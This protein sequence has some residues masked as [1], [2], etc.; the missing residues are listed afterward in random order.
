MDRLGWIDR[1]I[2]IAAVGFSFFAG[3]GGTPLF[4]K[5]EGAFCEA[6]REMVAGGDYV[7]PYLNG[8]PRYDKPILIYWLQAVGV[9]LFGLNEFAVRFPSAVAAAAWA[10]I[11]YRF[12][13]R[14]LDVEKAFLATF[15]L[16]TAVQVTIIA[17][18]AIADAVLNFFIALS[19]FSFYRYY[20]SGKKDPY[21]IGVTAMALGMLTKGPVAILIPLATTF[22]FCWL[23]K[24][25]KRWSKAVAN[26]WG[27]LLFLLIAGPWYLIAIWDQGRPILHAWI[28]KQTIQRLHRPLEGHGGRFYYY[29]PIVLGG[30]MPYTA[31]LFKAM[32]RVRSDFKAPLTR[33]LLIWFVFVFVFF[34]FSGTKLPHYVIY[35]Y[36]GLFIVFAMHLDRVRRDFLLMLPALVLLVLLLLPAY[37]IPWIAPRVKDE[38]ARAVIRECAGEFGWR[39]QIPIFAGLAVTLGLALIPGI[40]R[41]TRVVALGFLVA[42]LV[43]L[44]LMTLAGRITQAPVK[45]AA[46]IARQHDYD[47]RLWKF[48]MPSFI[49]YRE[50]LLPKGLPLEGDIVL[51]KINLLERLA[52][53]EIL[54][55]KN[56]VV[57]ARILHVKSYETPGKAN[58][59]LDDF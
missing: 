51:T 29:V 10:W 43:N 44:H 34:S 47:A 7:M 45:E 13:R 30:V 9:W 19:M 46:R 42:G 50:K 54:Y 39:Y 26:P 24:D 33:Y 3:L 52:E 37:L 1:G 35:G 16:V 49:F 21:Y 41:K 4:D 59:A 14:A 15:M 56:G 48:N 22:I 58:A 18:A 36:T 17:K 23:E 40:P 12:V 57:L 20:E 25:L 27:I 53:P 28:L 31:L 55:E 32:G 5:D 38:F 8:A 11:M 2:L 6:T